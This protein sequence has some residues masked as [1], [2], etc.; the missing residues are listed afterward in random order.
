[1]SRPPCYL[2]VVCSI[3]YTTHNPVQSDFYCRNS[4]NFLFFKY[5]IAFN[6]QKYNDHDLFRNKLNFW[7]LIFTR[8]EEHFLLSFNH[9]NRQHTVSVARSE[10]AFFHKFSVNE[11]QTQKQHTYNITCI[12]SNVVLGNLMMCAVYCMCFLSISFLRFGNQCWRLYGNITRVS[13]CVLMCI[14]THNVRMKAIKQQIHDNL[15]KFVFYVQ[16]SM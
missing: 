3:D 5:K 2:Q 8:S 7:L 11:N 14:C 12:D 16:F 13:V 4:M 1:M 15:Q 10:I 6:A 9:V